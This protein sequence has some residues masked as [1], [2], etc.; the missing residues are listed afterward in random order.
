MSVTYRSRKHLVLP[1]P[2]LFRLASCSPTL[3]DEKKLTQHNR[4]CEPAV[5]KTGFSEILNASSSC[6]TDTREGRITRS[7]NHQDDGLSTR[8]SFN[9]NE[10]FSGSDESNKSSL[11]D[12][13]VARLFAPLIIGYKNE[14]AP[15]C[16][17][18]MELEAWSY[19]S[20][21]AIARD[22]GGCTQD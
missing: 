20:P 8:C 2:L 1:P 6:G 18:D 13:I 21:N 19:G 4:S 7:P 14:N 22:A 3:F 5:W 9:N 11:E 10:L 12:V 17:F 15:N 16:L